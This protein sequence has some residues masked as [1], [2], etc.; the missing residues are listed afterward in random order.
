MKIILIQ[1]YIFSFF[2]LNSLDIILSWKCGADQIKIKPAAIPPSMEQK[3]RRLI[4][5]TTNPIKIIADYSNLR[6]TGS[7]NTETL[8]RIKNLLDQT[9]EEFGR[10][11]KVEH[12]NV[13]LAGNENLI[14]EQC[15]INN[16]GVDYQNFLIKNDLVIFPLFDE[17]LGNGVL[18]AAALCLYSGSNFRPYAGI[19]LINPNLSFSKRNTDIYMKNLFLHEL[20]HVL[21]FN[22]ELM[23]EL[24]M[25]TTKI[26]DGSFVTFINS[27][28]V[29]TASRQH[30]NC[31]TLNGI[32]LENQGSEGTAG[33][34][35][36]ARYMLG[37][38]MISTDYIDNVISDITLALFEDSGFYKV[39]YYSGG[40]FKFGKNMGCEFFD[41]KCV[42]NGRTDFEKD[43]CI[44]PNDNFC[45][46][47]RGFKGKC[48]ISSYKETIPKK[49]RYFSNSKYGGFRPANFCPVSN[50]EET[51]S[52]Y[53]PTS[54]FVGSS[55]LNSDY[56]EVISNS[57]FCFISSLLPSNSSL[58]IEEKAIC[59]RVNCDQYNKQIIVNI[60]SNSLICP[61]EGGIV[62]APNGFKG[63]IVCPEFND[64]CGVDSEDG[65]SCNEMF[66]CINKKVETG[67]DTFLYFLDEDDI[68][69]ILYKTNSEK[70][71]INFS[72]LILI[73][74]CYIYY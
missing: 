38:Y 22:P 27:P 62:S 65:S 26:F 7:V 34:H 43:F 31:R 41:K 45:S 4:Y 18:A 28:K 9:C 52:D 11:I 29:L 57:S 68:G 50:V 70:L 23:K 61:T 47:S 74:L 60:G 8:N 49:Y 35:W 19:L 39:E 10:F 58:S 63:S 40:L 17:T 51:E 48:L 14:K 73:L 15:Q 5:S 69:K 20:T 46:R 59:Y 55:N 36:E 32:P 42:E 6:A 37:D 66:N 71:Q 13:E 12:I 67:E 33:S 44:N 72:L 53:F 21:I 2:L 56:G 64:I 30:F 24:G 16:L 54:C 3:N 1:K 25:T